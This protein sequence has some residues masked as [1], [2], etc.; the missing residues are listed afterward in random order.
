MVF[1]IS[2]IQLELRKFVAP[3]FIFGSDARLSAGN[4]CRQLGGKKILLVTD[5][6]VLKTPWVNQVKETIE[7][8][9]LP[10]EIYS[11]ISPNPRDYEVMQ[12]AEFYLDK[13]CNLIVAIGGGSVIDCAK[14]IGIVSSNKKTIDYF[15]GVDKITNPM[16]PLICIPTTAGTAA[17]LS[18]F[19]II[20]KFDER[21]KMA[22]ISKAAVPDIALIDPSTLSTM[23]PF[24]TACTGLDALTHSMLPLEIAIS[25][26]LHS[27]LFEIQQTLMPE[28]QPVF[29]YIFSFWRYS[30]LSKCR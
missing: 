15:E 25:A 10:C 29:L 28:E 14:G 7:N 5:Q 11:S 26:A 1:N 13:Q 9:G 23:S 21:Y 27:K 24:L 4:Y 8:K 30:V 3:E 17:D 18:Q 20:N 6:G 22:I 2:D 16:P 12:G 19:A